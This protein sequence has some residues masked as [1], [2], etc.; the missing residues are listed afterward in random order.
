MEVDEGLY[1][2]VF[3]VIGY[4]KSFFRKTYFHLCGERNDECWVRLR[5]GNQDHMKRGVKFRPLRQVAI[6]DR[7]IAEPGEYNNT[8]NQ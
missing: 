7:S 5:R 8:V 1:A 2:G 4:R 6:V 3:V